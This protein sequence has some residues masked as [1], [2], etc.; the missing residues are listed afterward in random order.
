MFHCRLVEMHGVTGGREQ[1][2]NSTKPCLRGGDFQELPL[3]HDGRSTKFIPRRLGEPV[4]GYVANEVGIV[5][6]RG[7]CHQR[8]AL[9]D[10]MSFVEEA[11]FRRESDVMKH[12]SR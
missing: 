12:G 7:I 4:A 1:G 8:P 3:N 9:D 11:T 6:A 5:G 10:G 2:F